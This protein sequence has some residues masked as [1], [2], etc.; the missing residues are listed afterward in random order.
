MLSQ[1][2]KENGGGAHPTAHPPRAAL[3]LGR[4]GCE[5]TKPGEGRPHGETLKDIGVQASQL[6]DSEGRRCSL[7]VHRALEDRGCGWG[8]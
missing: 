2:G 7:F 8:Q 1:K 3:Q 6:E 4:A 5:V